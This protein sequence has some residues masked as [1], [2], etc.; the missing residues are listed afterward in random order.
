M[1]G[2]NQDGKLQC[3]TVYG[4]AYSECAHCPQLVNIPTG[5]FQM[6]QD[7]VTFATPE[8]AVTVPAFAMGAYEVTFDEWDAC[9]G[10]G[11]CG[12]YSPSDEGWG[13]GSRPVI[14]IS[15]DDIQ[16]Y[17]TWLNSTTGGG[18]RLPSESEWEYATR[19]GTITDYWFGD[20]IGVN[21][22]NCS[23][24]NCGDYFTNTAPVHTF[25]AN[26][27]GLHNVHGNVWEL[28]E[29]CWNADYTDAPSDGSAWLTGDC[30]R[31][32]VRGGSWNGSS[33]LVRSAS[34]SWGNSSYRDFGR[35]FRVA[36]DQN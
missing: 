28:V 9:V 8:H 36:Q 17:I 12:G 2:I 6:G 20:D 30:T 27:F 24:A 10:A 26:A 15:W 21:Q 32:V 31:C 25:S 3:T 5:T 7:G 35:G 19:A 29:D 1:S 23:A 14:H 4:Q 34:R 22:A 11:G 18:Y 16:T 13:R 33:G